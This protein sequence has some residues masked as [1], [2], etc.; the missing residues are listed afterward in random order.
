[1]IPAEFDKRNEMNVC[2]LFLVPCHLSSEETT[3]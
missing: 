2:E 1:M 3:C